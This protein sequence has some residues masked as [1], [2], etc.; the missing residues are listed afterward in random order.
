M[1]RPK[2]FQFRRRNLSPAQSLVFGLQVCQLAA[3][4][5]TAN[6]YVGATIRLALCLACAA[7]A[8]GCGSPAKPVTVYRPGLRPSGYNDYVIR[9]SE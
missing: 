3:C 9:R 5:A 7:V 8:G 4:H 1:V 6:P 2:T